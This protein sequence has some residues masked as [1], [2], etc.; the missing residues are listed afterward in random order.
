M[1]LCPGQNK[2]LLAPRKGT[3]QTLDLADI[4]DSHIVLIVRVEVRHMILSSGLDEHANDNSEESRN[5]WHYLS[6][7]W[8][9]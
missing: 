5:L 9:A 6:S 4:V 8:T 3:S 2:A 1:K 7:S